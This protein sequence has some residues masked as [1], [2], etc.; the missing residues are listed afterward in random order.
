[1]YNSTIQQY[2]NVRVCRVR[3]LVFVC[4]GTMKRPLVECLVEYA[5]VSELYAS[6]LNKQLGAFSFSTQKQVVMKSIYHP[7]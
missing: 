6:S 3:V 5:W 4:V 1:M 2:Y 7:L